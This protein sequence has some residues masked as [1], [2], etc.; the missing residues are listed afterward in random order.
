MLTYIDDTL[1]KFIL[2]HACK[3]S[4]TEYKYI[5]YERIDHTAVV[6]L[7]RPDKLNA[8]NLD[9]IAELSSVM[10]TISSDDSIKAV[11]ITGAG[12]KAFCAGADIEYMS[13]INP[14][15]AEQYAIK[16]HA[17]M[18]K[19]ENLNKPVIAAVNGYAL[20]GGC[21]LALATDI[22]IASKNAMLGQPEVNLGICPGWGG[23][24]RLA[25]IVGVAKAKE[26]IFTGKRI[27]AEEA[28]SIG[29][30]NKVVELPK[31]MEEALA[32]A[33]DIAKNSALAV[34]VSKMLIN[35]GVESDINTG[36]TLEVWG[37]SL[38]FSHSDRTERMTRFLQKK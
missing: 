25:R 9:V 17:S 10:D 34:R 20:G 11:I 28:L 36:L 38:C 4:M 3:P 21:E 26:L 31:L 33:N 18:S 37:W 8:M 27:S 5:L 22:R 19:I 15:E 23:T 24:Q 1:V 32:I 2:Y 13:K 6:R 12:E 16:G 7:N 35:R 29:L 30:V 14:L